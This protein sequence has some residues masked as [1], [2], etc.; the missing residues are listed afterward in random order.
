MIST[1]KKNIA[2]LIPR[3]GGPSLERGDDGEIRDPEEQ[4]KRVVI[5]L[6][7]HCTGSWRPPSK[8][9]WRG[10]QLWHRINRENQKA[11]AEPFFRSPFPYHPG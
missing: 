4:N 5:P 3:V 8:P 11:R 7:P 10:G 6:S 2:P 9:A 1:I